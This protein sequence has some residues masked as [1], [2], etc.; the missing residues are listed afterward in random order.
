MIGRITYWNNPK[1]YGFI[2]VST[3]EQGATIQ[4]QYFF[5]YKNFICG[6]TPVLDGMVVF[7]L[8]HPIASGKKVQAVG[9]RYATPA[10]IHQTNYLRSVMT[11]GPNALA[12]GAQ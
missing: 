5:H 10:E 7:N 3:T 4:S 2:T 8:G 9:I 6:E 12:G 11:A 1:G